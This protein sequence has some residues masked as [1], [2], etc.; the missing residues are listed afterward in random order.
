MPPTPRT[1]TFEL[2]DEAATEA[3]GRSLAALLKPNDVVALIGDLGAGK[4]RLVRAV[5][6]ALGADPDTITSPTFTLIHEY[7]DT[8]PTIYHFDVY[9]LRTPAEFEA[10]AP[11]DYWNAGGL[12]FVEWG[13]RVL[14]HLP[15]RAIHLRLDRP[16]PTSRTA[17]LTWPCTDP[18]TLV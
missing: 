1:E 4:T 11:E 9:R 7:T 5:A 6:T 18:R 13:D 12:C 3:F 10:L 15:A 2:P 17:T 14:N 16:T 8:R